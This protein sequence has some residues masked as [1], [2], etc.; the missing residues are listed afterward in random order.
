MADEPSTA[1]RRFFSALLSGNLGALDDLLTPDFLLVDVARGGEIGKEAFLAAIRT[2]R[3]SFERIDAG[4][5]RV[6]VHGTAAIVTGR[7][8]MAGHAGD[9]PF[10]AKSRYTHVFVVADGRWR[11]ASAQGTPIAED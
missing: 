3:L 5:P 11:L 8:S 10:S 2:G 4:E 9:A 6:R 1:D 7:T